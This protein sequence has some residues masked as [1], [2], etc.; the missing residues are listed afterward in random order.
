M[1]YLVVQLQMFCFR[2]EARVPLKNV[3]LFII[4]NE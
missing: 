1:Y 3:L 4:T 2:L